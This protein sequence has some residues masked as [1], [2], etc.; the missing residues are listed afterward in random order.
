MSEEGWASTMVCGACR[1][2]LFGESGKQ[3]YLIYLEQP[4]VEQ[5][6]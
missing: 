4:T 1:S 6:T 5:Q 3:F 2:V